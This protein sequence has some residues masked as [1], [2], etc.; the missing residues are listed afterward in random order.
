MKLAYKIVS[1]L[2][3]NI[4]FTSKSGFNVNEVHDT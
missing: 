1:S 3:S 4:A 2:D